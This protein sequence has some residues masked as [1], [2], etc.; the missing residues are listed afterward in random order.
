MSSSIDEFDLPNDGDSDGTC[1][2]VTNGFV[3]HVDKCEEHDHWVHIHSSNKSEYVSDANTDITT[4]T[5]L[6]TTV[7]GN[8]NESVAGSLN[9]DVSADLN[10][11]VGG[12][13]NES[14]AGSLNTD[15]SADL[16]TTVGGNRNESVAGDHEITAVNIRMHSEVFV[17]SVQSPGSLNACIENGMVDINKLAAWLGE[18][19]LS[20]SERVSSVESKV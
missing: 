6:N 12:N 19:S 1:T 8:R 16:N 5:D 13:R 18:W 9:T 14:V 2:S 10:T 20:I 15:V 7:G 17:K 11:T 4:G 3:L